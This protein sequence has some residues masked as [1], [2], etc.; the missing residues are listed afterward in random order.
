MVALPMC[1]RDIG[2]YRGLTLETY[3]G[4]FLNCTAKACLDFPL[5]VRSCSATGSD[6]APW[7]PDAK[8]SIWSL[9]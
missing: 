1:R 3:H 5:P 8:A 2:D 4:H 6:C 7:M 9:R